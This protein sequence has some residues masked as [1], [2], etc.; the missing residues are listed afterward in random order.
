MRIAIFHNRYKLPGGEDVMVDFE[1]RQLEKAGHE[2]RR[3]EVNNGDAIGDS[4]FAK[5]RGA[6]LT[7]AQA[8]WSRK[9]M[10]SVLAL[11]EDF[12]PDV[13]HVHNWFPLLSPSV[14]EAHRLSGIPVVQTLHN[15]RLFCAGGT[16]W[17]GREVCTDC[18]D[19]KRSRAIRRGCYRNSRTQSA[20]WWRT[21]AGGWRNGT[22]Q[23]AVD[24]YLAPSKIVRDLHIEAGLP[25]EKIRVVP[26]GC[27]DPGVFPHDG[28]KP[29]AIFVGRLEEEKGIRS[30]IEGWRALPWNLNIVGQGTLGNELKRKYACCPQI[31]FHGQQP[32][33]R[34]LEL[35]RQSS[36]AVV[37]SI[38]YEPFGLGVIEAMAIGRPVVT[39][40]AGAPGSLIEHGVS[41]VHVSESDPGSLSTACR[42]L[43]TNPH[44]TA[45]MG[46]EA[47]K[48]Y[49]RLYSPEAHIRKLVEVF[50]RLTCHAEGK[51]S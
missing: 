23:S 13:G 37:P 35:I 40:G 1:H 18:V 38:W 9:S 22:F 3:F 20:V 47:R 17:D 33:N 24:A 42:K 15:Y 34:V 14:Y 26:N 4:G 19:G 6:A 11:L 49:K 41:G 36:I 39:A 32:R 28:Q 12:R 45:H 48:R 16:C 21:M 44:H 43:L 50:E 7:A 51:C 46:S 5:L 2:V 27:D 8:G 29:E 30:L 25:A 10:K 31:R